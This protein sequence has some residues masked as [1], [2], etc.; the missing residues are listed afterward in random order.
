MTKPTVVPA[1]IAAEPAAATVANAGGPGTFDVAAGGSPVAWTAVS[2]VP[3]ITITAPTE[4]TV[5]DL[6]VTYTVALGTGAARTG[7]VL[8]GE[9]GLVHT[10]TQSAT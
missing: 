4:P 9:L 5:G 10:V 8:I 7:Q 3:W 2:S 1:A 6:E